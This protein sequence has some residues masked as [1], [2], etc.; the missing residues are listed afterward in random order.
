MLAEQS[1]IKVVPMQVGHVQEVDLAVLA[2]RP[3]TRLQLRRG[4]RPVQAPRQDHHL[5]GAHLRAEQGRDDPRG[6]PQA[7][8]GDERLG[9]QPDRRRRCE[10]VTK[11]V[12]SLL[13]A[14]PAPP[15]SSPPTMRPRSPRERAPD[16]MIPRRQAGA[17]YRSGIHTDATPD[18]RPDCP[19]R[20]AP[21]HGSSPP[22]RY[23]TAGM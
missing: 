19:L 5:P 22:A 7:D 3:G 11:D 16:P 1:R 20:Q 4:R 13:A 8:R 15:S 18:T 14:L 23:A 10:W 2:H 6:N 21:G 9:I 17:P 12:P